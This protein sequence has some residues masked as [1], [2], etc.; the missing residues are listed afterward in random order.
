MPTKEQQMIQELA[1]G[2]NPATNFY[3]FIKAGVLATLTDSDVRQMAE[4]R[5]PTKVLKAIVDV[6]ERNDAEI[7]AKRR[8]ELEQAEQEAEAKRQEAEFAEQRR[9]DAEAKAA[10]MNVTPDGDPVPAGQQPAPPTPDAAPVA[11]TPPVT[12]EPVVPPAPATTQP[13]PAPTAAIA[14][15]LTLISGIGPTMADR[16]NAE[17]VLTFA[18]LAVMADADITHL[19]GAVQGAT[20]DSLRAWRTEAQGMVSGG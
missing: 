12:P 5:L 1:E 9:R 8:A 2:M 19:A 3:A 17:S 20:E 10:E 14:D 4:A 6:R 11:T 7:A 13:A 18:D 15:D 16:L